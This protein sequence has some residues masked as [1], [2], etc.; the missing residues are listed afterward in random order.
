MTTKREV[1][2]TLVRDTEEWLVDQKLISFQDLLDTKERT[3]VNTE[4]VVA[5]IEQY[6]VKP[7]MCGQL[8]QYVR[9]E[10]EKGQF[11]VL[12]L[13]KFDESESKD[14]LERVA[15]AKIDESQ[16]KAMVQRIESII[17]VMRM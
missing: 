5:C 13:R 4:K 7:W 3:Q 16:V 11:L 1:I 10:I 2:A 9:S 17:K 6:C 12:K 8:E 15:S 14:V